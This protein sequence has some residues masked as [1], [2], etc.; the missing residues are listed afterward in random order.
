MCSRTP[1]VA[2]RLR[3]GGSELCASITAKFVL[4]G[5][6]TEILGQAAATADE[7]ALFEGELPS[8][9]VLVAGYNGQPPRNPLLN[10]CRI[11]VFCCVG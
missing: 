11:I 1:Q 2:A 8:Q 9:P 7:I 5:G 6:E 4:S 3:K 10:C